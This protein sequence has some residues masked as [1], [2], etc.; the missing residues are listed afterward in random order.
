MIRKM[1]ISSFN[2]GF[3]EGQQKLDLVQIVALIANLKIVLQKAKQEHLKEVVLD[4]VHLNNK[5]NRR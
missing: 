2:K 1:T 3:K 5:F 4:L